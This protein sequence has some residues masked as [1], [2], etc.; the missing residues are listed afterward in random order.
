MFK[1][2]QEQTK[3]LESSLKMIEVQQRL[4]FFWCHLNP[5]RSVALF[6]ASKRERE[7]SGNNNNNKIS[8]FFPSGYRTH[9]NN[10]LDLLETTLAR[11]HSASSLGGRE[12]SPWNQKRRERPFLHIFA[13]ANS[14]SKGSLHGLGDQLR[15]AASSI[16]RWHQRSRLIISTYYEYKYSAWKL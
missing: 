5:K 15:P 1:E 16:L 3:N 14:S 8:S 4:K 9:H 12:R 10:G 6:L 2:H 13:T 7:S 11:S